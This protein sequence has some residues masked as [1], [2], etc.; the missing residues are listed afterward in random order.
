MEHIVKT[1]VD[2]AIKDLDSAKA[3]A[4]SSV[5]RMEQIIQRAKDELATVTLASSAPLDATFM[6]ADAVLMGVTDHSL[7]DSD[8]GE[9]FPTFGLHYQYPDIKFNGVSKDLK[10]LKGR[11]KAIL[12]LFKAD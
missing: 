6:K 10:A 5:E 8:R 11:Y 9:I 1:I 2:A 12:L 4:A 7:G 3:S